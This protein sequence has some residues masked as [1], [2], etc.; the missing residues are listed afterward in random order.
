MLVLSAWT[1]RYATWSMSKFQVKSESRRALLRVLEN[2]RIQ[3]KIES[4]TEVASELRHTAWIAT[5]HREECDRRANLMQVLD[6]AT[7]YG[8]AFGY[9]KLRNE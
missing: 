6:N 8:N 4:A 7:T 1:T 3:D 2:H 5:R 9:V